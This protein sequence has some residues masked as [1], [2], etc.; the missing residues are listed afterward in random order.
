VR[1]RVRALVD[2]DVIAITAVADPRLFGLRSLAWLGLSVE[3]ARVEAVAESLVRMPYIDYVVITAGEM[4]VM[5]EAAC[6]TTDELYALV[7]TVRSLSGVAR[8]ET[9]VYLR[10][11]GQNFEWSR[12]DAP[13]PAEVRAIQT[14][15]LEDLD[16]AIFR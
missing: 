16:V 15:A 4:N 8:T 6:P 1:R 13:W 11:L 2:D 10:L 9:F 7:L 5:A 12:S 3:P 14:A